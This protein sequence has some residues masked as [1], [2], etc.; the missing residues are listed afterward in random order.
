MAS[1]RTPAEIAADELAHTRSLREKAE[2]RLT[3]AEEE[4]ERAKTALRDLTV[5]EAYQ[6]GH[7]L[8]QEQ[9]S[10]PDPKWAQETARDTEEQATEAAPVAVRKTATR[11]RTQKG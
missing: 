10:E 3:K 8:L 5:L 9:K 4:L 6:A 11:R 1:R 7:P 2:K